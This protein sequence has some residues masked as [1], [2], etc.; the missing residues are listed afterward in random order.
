MYGQLPLS[1]EQNQGQVESNVK[2]FS[3]GNGYTLFLTADEAVLALSSRVQAASAVLHMKLLGGNPAPAIAG[4]EELPG[5]TNYYTGKDPTRWRTNVAT[6]AKVTYPDVY[7]GIDLAYYGNQRQLEHDW[8]VRPGADPRAIRFAFEGATSIEVDSSGDLVLTT[9]AGE[10]RLRKPAIY[11]ESG[12]QRREIAGAFAPSSTGEVGFTVGGYDRA[13]P[14]VIDPVLAYSTYLGG[15]SGDSGSAIAVDATGS[16]YLTGETWSI[17]F[18]SDI[19]GPPS[20]RKDVFVTKLNPGGTALIYS[21]YYGGT[22]DDSARA[23]A[24]DSAGNA[25]VTGITSSADFPTVNALQ[26]AQGDSDDAFVAKF[27][28]S[29]RLVYSTYYGGVS[30]DY[31]YGI[32]ADSAGNAYVVGTTRSSRVPAV[33]GGD[34]GSTARVYRAFVAKL[35]PSGTGLVYHTYFGADDDETFGSAIAIDSGR[36]AYITGTI[37]SARFTTADAFVAKFSSSGSPV[38]SMNHGGSDWDLGESIALDSW[39]NVYV[40]GVT[41]SADFPVSDPLQPSRTG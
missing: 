26:P 24:I 18:P 28:D 1:F 40:A 20:S 9:G 14:L 21:A 5:K 6:Y 38:S 29:G 39:G 41:G 30:Y 4:F 34:P 10:V 32:A 2:F 31:G 17:D 13:R 15:S 37:Y 23:L 25:Y 27:D 19:P 3:R 7:P 35:D 33:P 11:Q 36:N 16:A 12:G 8:I 22:A